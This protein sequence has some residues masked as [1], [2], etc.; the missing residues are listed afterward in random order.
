MYAQTPVIVWSNRWDGG[1]EDRAWGL[2]IDS[3]ENIYICGGTT[4]NDT[5][6]WDIFIIKYNSSGEVIW[7]NRYN[8]E[9]GTR[10]EAIDIFIDPSDN[11]YI[12]G[13]TSLQ[14]IYLDGHIRKFNS[15]SIKLWETNYN[16]NILTCFISI[17]VDNY[18]NVYAGGSYYD[19]IDFNW[20]IMKWDS[21]GNAVWTNYYS[22]LNDDYIRGIAVDPTGTYLYASGERNGQGLRDFITIRYDP[23]TG[24][25]LWTNLYDAGNEEQ[26]MEVAIDN[27]GNAYVCGWREVAGVE[28]GHIKKYSPSGILL[29]EKDLFFGS[30]IRLNSIDLDDA[31]YIYSAGR[32]RI[33][34]SY[35][36]LAAKY[37]SA[38]SNVWVKTFG[39]SGTN[40]AIAVSV[41][42]NGDGYVYIGGQMFNGMDLDFYAVKMFQFPLAPSGL[43]AEQVSFD[44][45]QLSWHDNSACED[46]Y[47]IYRSIDGTNYSLFH[48]L[49]PNATSYNDSSCSVDTKYWYK[50]VATN[51][52]GET[53]S[54]ISN[55]ASAIIMPLPPDNPSGLKAVAISKYQ[56]DLA[57]NDLQN[58]ISYKLFRSEM[59]DT[60]KAVEIASLSA[61]QTNYSDI[62]L[63]PETIYYYW[64]KAVNTAGESDYSEVAYAKTKEMFP[65]V[66]AVFPTYF[67]PSKHEKAYIYFAGETPEVDV[68]IYDMQGNI[69]ERWDN[70]K[71]QRYIEWNGKNDNEK[72]V[73]AGIY[74][75]YIKGKGF[76]EKI[77]MI[78]VK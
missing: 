14:G 7:S 77:K 6:W 61:N 74:I 26:G 5:D 51:V 76:N 49:G 56:I 31:N 52:L 42:G 23:N 71:G 11:F 2:D 1:N 68:C 47:K 36:W 34:L 21:S 43:S 39:E 65:P 22:G 55:I 37:N 44:T 30:D 59:N 64:I 50:L 20:L 58:E 46:A 45:I 12:A 32:I 78:V 69:I 48:V 41:K 13:Y 29:W 70:L 63:E 54:S 57:W 16:A 27:N 25:A 40:M 53:E 62:G 72:K 73:N 24:I 33:G 9:A 4:N 28:R 17:M 66:W 15:N 3:Q 60:K 75:V 8:R 67:N 18:G 38:G 35:Y 19:F 10:D